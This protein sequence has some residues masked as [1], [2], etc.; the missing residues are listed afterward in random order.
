MMRVRRGIHR[1][2][3]L[4]WR[5]FAVGAALCGLFVCMLWIGA[6]AR[7][8]ILTTNQ[9]RFEVPSDRDRRVCGVVFDSAPIAIFLF[10]ESTAYTVVGQVP[11]DAEQLNEEIARYERHWEVY[12]RP[13][14]LP[15]P[16]KRAPD[17]EFRFGRESIAGFSTHHQARAQ[18]R[19]TQ[20]V[21]DDMSVIVTVAYPL[22]A[23]VC[24]LPACVWLTLAWRR[25]RVLRRRGLMG[26]C[27]ACGYSLRG[28]DAAACPECG[29]RRGAEV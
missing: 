17:R 13:F 10:V 16:L 19:G 22:A 24:F 5:L 20:L 11:L 2:F 28:I 1:V 7:G 27:V 23:G 21:T 4:G 25:G 14:V 9:F 8:G 29:C 12:Q 3:S 18:L 6:V 26:M 15:V